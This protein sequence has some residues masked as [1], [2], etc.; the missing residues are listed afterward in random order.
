MSNRNIGIIGKI[1]QVLFFVFVAVMAISPKEHMLLS[2]AAVIFYGLL[3]F[4]YAVKDK[5][6]SSIKEEQK[7]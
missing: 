1:S 5:D 2:V 6:A 4:L 7:E 3:G